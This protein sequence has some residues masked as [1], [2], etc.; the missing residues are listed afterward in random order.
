M[1]YNVGQQ[2]LL[3]CKIPCFVWVWEIVH[4]IE[5]RYCITRNVKDL[6]YYA[7]KNDQPFIPVPSWL[8]TSFSSFCPSLPLPDEVTLLWGERGAWSTRSVDWQKGRFSWSKLMWDDDGEQLLW[9]ITFPGGVRLLLRFTREW[10]IGRVWVPPENIKDPFQ[11]K[12]KRK[13]NTRLRC[14]SCIYYFIVQ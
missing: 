3:N 12:K 2:V 4:Y 10:S 14:L 11:T 1:F 9:A 6:L 5:L 7:L 13:N 8:K